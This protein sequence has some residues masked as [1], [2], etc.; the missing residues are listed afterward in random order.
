MRAGGGDPVTGANW[1]PP[2]AGGDS[3]PVVVVVERA[4]AP[5]LVKVFAGR[6]RK[7]PRLP[8]VIRLD[9]EDVYTRDVL[10]EELVEMVATAVEGLRVANATR[11]A[12]RLAVD[13]GEELIEAA[14]ADGCEMG[15]EWPQLL[16]VV[17]ELRAGL[18]SAP[19]IA[20][21]GSAESEGVR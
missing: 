15:A 14:E 13:V 1:W 6:G 16:A 3:L 7:A 11:G 18:V 21:R 4:H 2:A 19:E 9:L 20:G 10:A 17:D 5:T 12:W 8:F